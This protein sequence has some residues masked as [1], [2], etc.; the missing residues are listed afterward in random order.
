MEPLLEVRHLTI[1]YEEAQKEVVRDCSLSLSEREILGI[2]GES[3]SGKTTL[4]MSILGFLKEGAVI[5]EGEIRYG[6]KNITPRRWQNGKE[7]R[8][9]EERSQL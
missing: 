6:G 3:G 4:V 9:V 5:R 1:A 7:G 2:V 8:S